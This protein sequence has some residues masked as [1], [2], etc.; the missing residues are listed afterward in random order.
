MLKLILNLLHFS[1]MQNVLLQKLGLIYIMDLMKDI[2]H[3]KNL[4]PP[5]LLQGR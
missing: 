2:F 1:D 3:K 4:L 5:Q